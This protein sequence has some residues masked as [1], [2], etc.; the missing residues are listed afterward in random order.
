MLG[1]GRNEALRR[2]ADLGGDGGE[3]ALVGLVRDVPFDVLGLEAVVVQQG[4]NRAG[5]LF[6]RMP[7]NFAARHVEV[8]HGLGRAWAALGVENVD[9]VAVGIHLQV[10]DPALL[11]VGPVVTLQHHSAGAITKEHAGRAVFPVQDPAH[12]LRA[13][14]QRPFH[15][16]GAQQSVCRAHAVDKAR[17]NRLY[18]HSQRARSDAKVAL[19]HCGHGRKGE[20]RRGSRDDDAIDVGRRQAR[21]LQRIARGGDGEGRGGFAFTSE[22]T[23]ADA[24]ARLDPLVAGFQAGREIVILNGT[25]RQGA[26]DAADKDGHEQDSPERK[27]QSGMARAIWPDNSLSCAH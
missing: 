20:V 6:N 8:P 15:P 25:G 14:D 11:R 17:A 26:A 2:R 23:L 18:V 9:E 5:H 13:D 10:D 21:V 22:V 19:D 24:G 12:G 16:A 4:Q 7:E 3:N 1:Y 27:G